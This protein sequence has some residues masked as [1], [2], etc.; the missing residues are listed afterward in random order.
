[1]AFLDRFRK[2]TQDVL[3]SKVLICSLGS[4]FDDFLEKDADTYKR[5]FQNNTVL[6][7]ANANE[8]MDALSGEYDIVHVL[9]SVSPEGYIGESQITGTQL[10][11]RSANLGTKLLWL[12]TDNDPAGYIKNFKPNGNKL[13][14]VMTIQRNG[15][16]FTNFLNNLLNGMQSGESMPVAWNN[17]C[18]QIP[19][20]EH[21]DTPAT[22][23]FAGL[24][25]IRFV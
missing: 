5:Y 14:L 16:S 9:A 10:I 15:E 1:M 19:G 6:R 21:P 18:P 17:L 7:L 3:N 25:Q 11:Q 13:N 12:A 8:L 20:H 24:G 2:R 4:A 23:F 22:I